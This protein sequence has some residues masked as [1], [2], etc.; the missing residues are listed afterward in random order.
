MQY[1]SKPADGGHLQVKAGTYADVA[2]DLVARK[3]LRPFVGAHELL[4]RSDRWCLWL[5]DLTAGDEASSKVLRDRIG[6]VRHMRLASSKPST[7]AASKIAHLF[8]EIRQPLVPYLAIPVHVTESRKYFTA[9]RFT[10]DVICGNANF[11]AEDQDGFL[12][13]ITSSSMFI[14]WHRMIGGRIKSDLR[15]SNT[16]VWNNL[17]FPA[18]P[19]AAREDI[20][21]AGAQILQARNL[22]PAR[23]L[24]QHYEPGRMT[25]ELLSAHRALDELVDR[26]FGVTALC[27]SERDR[28]QILFAAHEQLTAPLL[29]ASGQKR[30]R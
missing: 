4:S 3:C 21:R 25:P 6:K 15:F 5:V 7:R 20:I 11:I 24:G 2:A 10:A 14:T 22:H 18:P 16:I 12:F 23:S 17:P 29:A 26:A 8:T 27:E 28:Q 9:T 13:S 19:T 30:R 1:G